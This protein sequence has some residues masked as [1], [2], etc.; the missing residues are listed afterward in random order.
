MSHRKMNYVVPFSF[1]C[2]HFASPLGTV[3]APVTLNRAGDAMVQVLMANCLHWGS[4]VSGNRIFSA[5]ENKTLDE[6][7]LS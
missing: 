6:K 4:R 2:L 3:L 5:L 7:R 1:F